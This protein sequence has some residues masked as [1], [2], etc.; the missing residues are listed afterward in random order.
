MPPEA[1]K[2]GAADLGLGGYVTTN[3]ERARHPR[4]GLGGAPIGTLRTWPAAVSRAGYRGGGVRSPKRRTGPSRSLPLPTPAQVL[5]R[6]LGRSES[7]GGGPSVQLRRRSTARYPAA[8]VGWGTHVR[9]PETAGAPDRSTRT[10]ATY[11]VVQAY[12]AP[13]T[14]TGRAGGRGARSACSPPAPPFRPGPHAGAAAGSS[15]L[16]S[17]PVHPAQTRSSSSTD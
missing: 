4:Q 13:P 12:Q 1:G 8:V 15:T 17:S 5:L 3:Q 10:R 14:G 11:N 16:T 9:T 6:R 7:P 2:R